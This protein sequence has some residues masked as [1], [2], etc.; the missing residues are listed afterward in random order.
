MR[1]RQGNIV[2][3][4]AVLSF[5]GVILAA[6]IGGIFLLASKGCPR[7]P[8][9]DKTA[10][11]EGKVVDQFGAALGDVLVSLRGGPQTTADTQGKFVL[12]DAS[13]GIK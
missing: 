12:N 7:T 10:R 3:F 13:A 8:G 2:K 4:P 5:A 6:L 1:K 9:P 11:L